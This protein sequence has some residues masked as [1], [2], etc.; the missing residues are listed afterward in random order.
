ML[1]SMGY[2]TGIDLEALLSA[3]AEVA[4]L[5]PGEEWFGFTSAAGLPKNFAAVSLKEAS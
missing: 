4:K 3:R 2:S 5:L 1:E